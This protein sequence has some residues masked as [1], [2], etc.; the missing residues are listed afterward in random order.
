MGLVEHK[1]LLMEEEVVEQLKLRHEQDDSCRWDNEA[2][3]RNRILKLTKLL[4]ESR[5]MNLCKMM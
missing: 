3:E 4:K 1:G 5:L 2:A